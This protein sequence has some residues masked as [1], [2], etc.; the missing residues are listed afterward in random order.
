MINLGVLSDTHI[1]DKTPRLSP[2]VTT[3]F[4]QAKVEAIL[5]AGDVTSPQVLVQLKQVA[6]VYAVLGNQD[7]FALRHLPSQVRLNLAGSKI[8]MAHGHGTFF[9]YWFD[10]IDRHIRGR[11]VGRYLRRMLRTFPDEDVIVF[12]H[13]HV[14]CSFHINGK[15]LFNPGSTTFPWPRSEPPSFGMLYL[16]QGKQPQ[17]EIIEIN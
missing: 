16:E 14:S 15:L 12:G 3:H 11:Y 1:P 8:G 9:E 6:P 13:L 2:I 17:G 10:K 5:H 7:I 4:R